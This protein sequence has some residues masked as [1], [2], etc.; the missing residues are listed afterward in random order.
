MW[1]YSRIPL[2]KYKHLPSLPTQAETGCVCLC[3]EL[4]TAPPP[5]L[6]ATG[7]QLW[8]DDACTGNTLTLTRQYQLP[9][10]HVARSSDHLAFRSTTSAVL[11]LSQ[12]ECSSRVVHAFESAEHASLLEGGE[13]VLS[14][15]CLQ[16]RRDNQ[17]CAVFDCQRHLCRCM[18]SKLLGLRKARSKRLI[19]SE[20]VSSQC[21]S[22]KPLLKI[23]PRKTSSGGVA[24]SRFRCIDHVSFAPASALPLL[25]ISQPTQEQRCPRGTLSFIETCFTSLL[26]L[27]VKTPLVLLAQGRFNCFSHLSPGTPTTTP[28]LAL[29]RPRRRMTVVRH[30]SSVSGMQEKVLALTQK[31]KTETLVVFRQPRASV[32]AAS[33]RLPV[34]TLRRH[35]SIERRFDCANHM[36][37]HE[38]QKQLI[39]CLLQATTQSIAFSLAA[40][41]PA[42][43]APRPRPIP[44]KLPMPK[45]T[46]AKKQACPVTVKTV[47]P[48]GLFGK[49]RKGRRCRQRFGR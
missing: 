11:S 25:A 14:V 40:R 5:A 24:S 49:T 48:W 16:Q 4:T 36:S 31:K 1:W 26:T 39:L 6:V 27:S 45:T 15:A 13:S 10:V 44:K 47:T 30:V 37:Q 41:R 28:V 34:I 2:A 20:H 8:C 9:C 23:T 12:F 7:E 19:V 18:P 21:S 17:L 22:T 38:K 32:S 3:L 42:Q 43:T 29:H 46:S 35:S 33:A